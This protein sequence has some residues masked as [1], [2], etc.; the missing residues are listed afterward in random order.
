MGVDIHELLA[1]DWAQPLEED[2]GVKPPVSCAEATAPFS[3]WTLPYLASLVDDP[4]HL[5]LVFWFG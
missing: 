2:E 1:F 3:P 5:R 4:R